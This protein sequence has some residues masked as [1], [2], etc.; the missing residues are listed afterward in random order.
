MQ[1][2]SMR[3][4]KALVSLRIC[5][6]LP[7]HSLRPPMRYIKK[8]LQKSQALPEGKTLFFLLFKLQHYAENTMNELLSIFGYEDKVDSTDTD[9]L[10]LK[11]YTHAC[12]QDGSD[13]TRGDQ[14]EEEEGS[15]DDGKTAAERLKLRLRNR[16]LIGLLSIFLI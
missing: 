13:V 16:K 11:K 10:D 8:M 9:K 12:E 7:E 1:N 5:V 4:A 6:G 15:D 3:A 14:V 2:L